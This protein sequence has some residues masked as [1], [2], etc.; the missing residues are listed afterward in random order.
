MPTSALRSERRGRDAD[1]I[2]IG[3]R[4]RADDHE[5]DDERNA[6]ELAC[7]GGCV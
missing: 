2:E 6:D 4:R 7:D 5:Q 1:E 3:V